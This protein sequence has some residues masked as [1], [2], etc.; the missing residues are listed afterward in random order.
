ML[1]TNGMFI[2]FCHAPNPTTKIDT[3]QPPHA[4]KVSIQQV[5]K[6]FL[7]SKIYPQKLKSINPKYLNNFFMNRYSHKSQFQ[8]LIYNLNGFTSIISMKRRQHHWLIIYIFYMYKTE[9][10]LKP[11]SWIL[12]IPW[13]NLGL[14]I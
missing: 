9:G 12:E 3:W 10:R 2:R 6:V 11:K 13:L 1:K 4:Y 7:A 5:C 14:Y 8:T